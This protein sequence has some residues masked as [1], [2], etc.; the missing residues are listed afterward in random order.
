MKNFMVANRTRGR[1]KYD[2]IDTLLKAQIENSIDLGWEPEDII[3]L[4]NFD[5]EFMG[6]KSINAKLNKSCFTGSKMFG[7]EYLFENDIVNDI[8]WAHDLDAWQNVVFHCPEFKDVG[9]ACYSTSKYNGG[10]IFWKPTSKD[11]VYEILRIIRE[12]KDNKEEPTLNKVLKSKKY[13]NRVTT[14]NNTF[15]VGCSGYTT[16]WDRSIKPIR[17][18]HFHPYNFIAWET[19]VLDRNGLDAKGISD[20]LED[21]LRKYYPHLATQLSNKGKIAQSQRRSTRLIA[22]AN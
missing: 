11:I 4:A 19:H 16:R 17:V 6:V 10:S 13:E 3:L 18:C 12:N 21:L 9:V 20:R 7:M 14:I 15:N 8:I 22:P 5:Y 1:Y 2:S